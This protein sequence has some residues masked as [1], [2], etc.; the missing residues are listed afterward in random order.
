MWLSDVV[1]LV[2]SDC[3]HNSN[4]GRG[5]PETSG[6]SPL[7]ITCVRMYFIVL[8]SVSV[9][10]DVTTWPFANHSAGYFECCWGGGPDRCWN[11]WLLDWMDGWVQLIRM[12][13]LA[14]SICSTRCWLSMVV[15]LK[16]RW[17]CLV[18][19]R[20]FPIPSQSIARTWSTLTPFAQKYVCEI[21]RERESVCVWVSVYLFFFVFVS[22]PVSVA[23][24]LSLS[25]LVA[26]PSPPRPWP[27]PSCF[28]SIVARCQHTT[29]MWRG[30]VLGSFWQFPHQWLLRVITSP[31]FLHLPWLPP[32]C[33]SKS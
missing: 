14:I 24:S 32:A 33:W 25:W 17:F 12:F 6:S 2:S 19:V 11:A 29:L 8:A 7:E 30:A 16:S 15:P 3:V 1:D 10:C 28:S 22:L 18:M 27:S 13:C 4:L 20:G 31:D 23:L 5:W 9:W 26:W 21:E